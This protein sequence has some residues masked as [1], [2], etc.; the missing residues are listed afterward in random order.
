M[1]ALA[2]LAKYTGRYDVGLQL[3]QRYNLKWSK[4]DSIESF[5]RF[6]EDGLNYDVMLQQIREMIQKLPLQM[7]NIIKFDCLTGLRPA[8]AVEAIRLINYVDKTTIYY[9]PERMAL[10][11]FRFPDIFFRQTKKVY[12]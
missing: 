4:G 12:I 9:K 8:E 1:T 2:N 10:E 6:F 3:R 11:H 5:E 7:A